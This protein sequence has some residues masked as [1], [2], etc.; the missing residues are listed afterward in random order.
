MNPPRA[1]AAKPDPAIWDAFHNVLRNR[2][3]PQRYWP[4]Y[5]LRAENYLKTSDRKPLEQHT[6]DDLSAYWRTAGAANRLADWPYRPIVESLEILFARVLD[7]P[8]ARDFDWS[9]ETRSGFD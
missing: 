8:W 9:Y 1:A 4:W 7:L 6:A 5:V 2:K 3:I